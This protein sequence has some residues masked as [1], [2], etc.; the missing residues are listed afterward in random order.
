M[1]LRFLKGDW[2]FGKYKLQYRHF[3]SD[4]GFGSGTPWID[5][6]TEIS[7]EPSDLNYDNTTKHLEEDVKPVVCNCGMYNCNCKAVKD[8]E[9]I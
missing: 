2:E 8:S 3:G 4:K 7:S 6:P 5:V 1:E 9:Q